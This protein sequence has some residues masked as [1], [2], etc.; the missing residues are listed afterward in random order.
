MKQLEQTVQAFCRENSIALT[1]SYDM[2][3][4]YETAYGTYD[5]TVNTL[6]LNI[7]ILQNAPRY[8]VLF[9]LFH[10]LRHAMQY[11]CPMLFNEQI[12][13]SMAYVILYNGTCYKLVGNVWQECVLDGNEDYF[14]RA[15]MSLP[16]EIDANTFA[17]EMV[18]Q[19]CGDSAQLQELL[20]FWIPKESFAYEEHRK[21]FRRIDKEIEKVSLRGWKS[22][23]ESMTAKDL[24]D[25]GICPTCYDKA[26]N[27]IL[28]GDNSGKMLLENDIF[29]CFLAGN[30][31]SAGHTIISTK[32]HYKDMMEAPD[33][34]VQPLFVFARKCMNAL[35]AI[36]GSESVY[37]CTMCDGPMNHFHVQLI[38]R[39]AHEKRGSRNFV[40]ERME[41]TEDEEKIEK[42]RSLLAQKGDLTNEEAVIQQ[43][44]H[45]ELVTD[46]M[47]NITNYGAL[48][49]SIMLITRKQK[50]DRTYLCISG[51][52][53]CACLLRVY[54]FSQNPPLTNCVS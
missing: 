1:L 33:E 46:E 51:D 11:L 48:K 38:P 26:N 53:F 13:E 50:S 18:K 54:N 25:R 20:A 4:G 42:M 35:K 12:K 32:E 45:S 7:A 52:R 8:E 36:Y 49:Q 3:A 43:G 44:T 29:E 19:I 2:P 5:V 37:L 40:K 41:Y 34:V 17:H 10:E 30:P 22:K 14:T 27:H 39:Y 6:F 16:Y 9:Y 28:Y 47:A 15:Y 21:L 31:R 24:V 23:M